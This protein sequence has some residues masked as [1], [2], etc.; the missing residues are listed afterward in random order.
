MKVGGGRVQEWG[1]NATASSPR[2]VSSRAFYGD[3]PSPPLLAHFRERT[4]RVDGGLALDVPVWQSLALDC[5]RKRALSI[6]P[7]GVILAAS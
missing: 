2:F 3:E 7:I 1:G 5:A 4:L 6:L